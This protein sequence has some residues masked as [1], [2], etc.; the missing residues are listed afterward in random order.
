MFGHTNEQLSTTTPDAAITIPG[1]TFVTAAVQAMVHVV[2]SA[3]NNA[4]LVKLLQGNMSGV[5]LLDKL[6]STQLRDLKVR[7][8]LMH[9]C[10]YYFII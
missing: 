3:R 7:H 6:D 2:V 4:M 5:D 1:N 8:E 10:S 9:Q